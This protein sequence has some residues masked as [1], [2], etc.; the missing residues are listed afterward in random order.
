MKLLNIH[1]KN[2]RAHKDTHIDFTTLGSPVLIKG[3]NMDTGASNG[4]GKT[5]IFAAIEYAIF[6]QKDSQL[7][8]FETEGYV[9]LEFLA[10]GS[11]YRIFKEYTADEYKVTLYKDGEKY[12]T[13]KLEIEKYLRDILRISRK[14]FQ[15]TIYQPQGFSDFFSFLTPQLKSQFIAE[16][17][18]LSKWEDYYKSANKMANNIINY[19]D[20]LET[21]IENKKIDSDNYAKALLLLNFDGITNDL[22][23]NRAILAGKLELLKSYDNIHLVI[24]ER[25]KLEGELK[26][27]EEAIV[28][29]KEDGTT[30]YNSWSEYCTLVDNIKSRKV[31]PVADS[32]KTGVLASAL[33]AE[34]QLSSREQEVTSKQNYLL[35][36]DNKI[37]IVESH[38]QCPYCFRGFATQEEYDAY[39]FDI[40]KHVELE[41]EE[42]T[43][44]EAIVLSLTNMRK[45]QAELIKSI[46][47]QSQIYTEHIKSYD[48]AV[49]KRD[50][51]NLMVKVYTDRLVVLD[52]EYKILVDKYEVTSGILSNT[53][54]KGVEEINKDIVV[55][56]AKLNS[57]MHDMAMYKVTLGNKKNVDDSI[58][59]LSGELDRYSKA[60]KL[61]KSTA[62]ALSSSGIQKWLFL[63]ALEEMSALTN[64][65][66][67]PVGYTLTFILEK[68]KA[69]EGEYKPA[70]DI[71]VHYRGRTR[72][73]GNLSGGEKSIVNFAI[74][75]AFSTIMASSYGFEFLIIDEGFQDMDDRAVSMVANM[76]LQLSKQFQILTVTHVK[77]FESYFNNVL[78]I[79]KK[80]DI[81][82]VEVLN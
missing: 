23:N 67:E 3:I 66:L 48:D 65:L 47:S 37:S 80:N 30:Y 76:L 81:A 49:Q 12:L 45:E 26:D 78:N 5:S 63:S 82:T 77:E 43:K 68:P 44:L 29:V 28:K 54:T 71:Q 35:E 14:L 62:S 75:L 53:D 13:A 11:I 33:S 25:K 7:S 8:D 40:R 57:L 74:R 1:L 42:V 36:M 72:Y 16:L 32:Y 17:L 56:N 9:S 24:E 27:K 58:A 69:N 10:E 20:K 34:K 59:E 70:F 79:I 31:T 64:S 38:K 51:A 60:A 19:K 61:M 55:I 46:N 2:F 41:K 21:K 52:A 15:Q 18:N 4:A 6:S 73:V 39:L 22:A 50:S